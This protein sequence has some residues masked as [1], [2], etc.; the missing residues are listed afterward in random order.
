[1][2][3][4][5]FFCSLY[6]LFDAKYLP[7]LDIHQDWCGICEAIH[8][9]FLRVFNEYDD[10]ESRILLCSANISKLGPV[11]QASLPSD[12][13]INLEK[14]GCIPVF[15]L[16]RFKQCVSVIVGV[17][18]PHLLQQISINIPDKANVKD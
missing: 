16:Y 13:H 4:E 18:G 2:V 5:Q 6:P 11:I 3:S 1:L 10:S 15:A 14:N 9:T 7:V 8:P 12:T 17:D